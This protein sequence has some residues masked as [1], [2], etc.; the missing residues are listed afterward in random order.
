MSSGDSKNDDRHQSLYLTTEQYMYRRL[1]DMCLQYMNTDR[2]LGKTRDRAWNL[3]VSREL[4]NI[5][6]SIRSFVQDEKA[7]PENLRNPPLE[8][9][10]IRDSKDPTLYILHPRAAKDYIMAIYREIRRQQSRQKRDVF[11]VAEKFGL[12]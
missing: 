12:Q 3:V 5:F 8:Q 11:A 1:A 7:F 4:A 6:E 10:T 9:W 2:R